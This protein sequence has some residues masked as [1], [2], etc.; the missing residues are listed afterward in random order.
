MDIN[1]C[2]GFVS[3]DTYQHRQAIPPGNCAYSDNM[4]K[5]AELSPYREELTGQN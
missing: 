1:I 2:T 3:W 5:P 4:T